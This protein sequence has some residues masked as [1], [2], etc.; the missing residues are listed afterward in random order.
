M[1]NYQHVNNKSH[2][3]I[4]VQTKH[5]A[6]LGDAIASSLTFPTEFGDVHSEYPILFRKDPQTNDFC[7]IAVF[8]FEQ[9]ENLFLQDEQ[10][11][12]LFIDYLKSVRIKVK[13]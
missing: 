7:S 10:Y 12:L 1:S 9:G 13:N 8:G 2:Q 3:D 5:S 4:K 6:L 11:K